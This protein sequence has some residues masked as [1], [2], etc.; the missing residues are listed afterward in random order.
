MIESFLVFKDLAI[1]FA[2][3]S[4]IIIKLGH[5]SLIIKLTPYQFYIPIDATL[6]ENVQNM[7]PVQVCTGFIFCTFSGVEH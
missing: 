3:Y 1:Q 5:Y 2:L 7:K 4:Q 6:A